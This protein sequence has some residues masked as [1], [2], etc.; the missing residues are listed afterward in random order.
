M[1]V[2]LLR[3]RFGY[4]PKKGKDNKEKIMIKCETQ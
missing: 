4:S 2:D 1:S 3:E